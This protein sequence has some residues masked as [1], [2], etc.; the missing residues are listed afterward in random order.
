SQGRFTITGYVY[1]WV[2]IPKHE[3]EWYHENRG[4]FQNGAVKRSHEILTS[5]EIQSYFRENPDSLDLTKLDTY[6]NGT[7]TYQE[8]GDGIFDLIIL[9]DRGVT[10]P[11]LRRLASGNPSSGSSISSLGVD[12]EDRKNMDNFIDPELNAF[13]SEPVELGGMKVIDNLTSG[14]GIITRALTRKQAVR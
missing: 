5:E 7:N 12:L 10:L 14:S 9:I 4:T 2:Y 13:A 8:G 3:V 11:R 6:I 1:P